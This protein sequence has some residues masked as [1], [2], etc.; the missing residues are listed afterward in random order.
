[1]D[2]SA[3]VTVMTR[4][5][6]LNLFLAPFLAAAQPAD[7][8][9]LTR[10]V[11]KGGALAKD[12]LEVTPCPEAIVAVLYDGKSHLVR[13]ARD[14]SAGE[15]IAA[16]PTQRMAM[17]VRGQPVR[18]QHRIGAISVTRLGTALSDAPPG[19]SVIALTADGQVIHGLPLQE[20][21]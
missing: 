10:P 19:G 7:C 18:I 3:D 11:D 1:M 6:L 14:M 8:L 4:I 20:S 2:L 13:A 5:A 16:V 15:V 17:A 9:K 12:G 21:P